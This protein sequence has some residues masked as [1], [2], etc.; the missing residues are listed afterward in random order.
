MEFASGGDT[1]TLINEKSSRIRLFQDAGEN[2]V[3][4]ILAC[5]ILGM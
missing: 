5:L 4:F 2:A 3:R 1:Y